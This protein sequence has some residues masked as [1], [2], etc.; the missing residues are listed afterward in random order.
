MLESPFVN[1]QRPTAVNL[2]RSWVGNVRLA[3]GFVYFLMVIVFRRLIHTGIAVFY[4]AA[5]ISAGVLIALGPP[6][7]WPVFAGVMVTTLILL[8]LIPDLNIWSTLSSA[9]FDSVE[10][11]IIAGLFTRYFGR[12]FTFDR[13]R[14]VLGLFIAILVGTVVSSFGYAV[15]SLLLFPR[16]FFSTWWLWSHPTPLVR[17]QLLHS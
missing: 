14:D 7:R 11:L 13:L 16:P 12:D 10:P 1:G 9:L 15:A 2:S 8:I 17:F 6:A 3:A 4:P 5:G